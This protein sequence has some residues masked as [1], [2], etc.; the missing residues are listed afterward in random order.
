M[1]IEKIKEIFKGKD[2]YEIV[3]SPEGILEIIDG[4]NDLYVVITD[5]YQKNMYLAGAVG[6]A[7]MDLIDPEA[8]RKLDLFSE[9]IRN[10]L[11]SM[12]KVKGEYN[13]II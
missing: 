12:A 3:E 6:E 4:F 8:V 5:N 1:S 11:K 9:N 2:E 7:Y 13:E 10:I